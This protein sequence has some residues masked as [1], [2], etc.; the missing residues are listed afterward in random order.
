MPKLQNVCANNFVSDLMQARP[1][2][3][4][5]FPKGCYPDWILTGLDAQTLAFFTVK[6]S[7]GFCK[8]ILKVQCISDIWCY[9]GFLQCRIITHPRRTQKQKTFIILS[10]IPIIC[11]LL[12]I[13]YRSI[14]FEHSK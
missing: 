5:L 1:L 2:R 4:R 6:I 14:I 13:V 12:F 8:R 9:L 10:S 3:T 7:A 11:L